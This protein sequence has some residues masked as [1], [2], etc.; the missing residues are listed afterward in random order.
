[1]DNRVEATIDGPIG[2][3]AATSD[4]VVSPCETGASNGGM[5]LL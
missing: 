1:M 3:I 2:A 5:P 4:G